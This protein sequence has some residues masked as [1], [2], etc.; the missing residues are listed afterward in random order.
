MQVI[1]SLAIL[2]AGLYIILSKQYGEADSKWAYG[3]VGTV[4]G[5]WLRSR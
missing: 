2:A 3:I 1:G 5:Y 4:I